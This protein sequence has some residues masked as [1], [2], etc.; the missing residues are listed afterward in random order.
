MSS[1]G[2]IAVKWGQAVMRTVFQ[3]RNGP[4]V[5]L[6]KDA[7][8][9]CETGASRPLAVDMLSAMRS[10]TISDH[11]PLICCNLVVSRSAAVK[12]MFRTCNP[13]VS[14]MPGP[15]RPRAQLRLSTCIPM[16]FVAAYARPRRGVWRSIGYRKIPRSMDHLIPM[17]P[18]FRWVPLS[19]SESQTF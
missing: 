14:D 18:E 9:H 2:D 7:S 16:T 17:N 11:K 19:V 15:S 1:G 10:V 12:K 8:R 13:H 4:P 3:G 6:I 5:H